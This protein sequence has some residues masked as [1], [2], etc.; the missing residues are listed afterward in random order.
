MKWLNGS[1]CFVLFL[2]LAAYSTMSAPSLFA[3]DAEA[4]AIMERVDARD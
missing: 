1:K 3:D 2:I 4:R